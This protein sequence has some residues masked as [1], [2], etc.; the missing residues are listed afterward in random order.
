MG[1]II[2][3]GKESVGELILF[4]GLLC[5]RRKLPVAGSVGTKEGSGKKICKRVVT[6][7][8]GGYNSF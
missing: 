1:I 3:V 7:S 5:I 2:Y 4:F 8:F 6:L